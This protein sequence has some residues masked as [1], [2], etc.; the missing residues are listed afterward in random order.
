MEKRNHFTTNTTLNELDE[1][2]VTLDKKNS[3][4]TNSTSLANDLDDKNYTHKKSV[5]P[6]MNR[7]KGLFEE[8]SI[9]I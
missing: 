1:T 6:K 5:K 8:N 7:G 2:K 9:Q 4:F 3:L